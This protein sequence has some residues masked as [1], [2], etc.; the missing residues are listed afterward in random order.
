MIDRLEHS[1]ERRC[2]ACSARGNLGRPGQDGGQ[3]CAKC[4]AVSFIVSATECNGC[5][6]IVDVV[7][8]PERKNVCLRCREDSSDRE[9]LD[10]VRQALE[11]N[12]G[13]SD[14]EDK[15]ILQAFY[16][17]LERWGAK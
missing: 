16:R 7:S 12:F 10:Q 11:D 14:P 8:T 15:L 17:H 3:M 9:D 1:L 13:S 2:M 4:G 5:R 6:G